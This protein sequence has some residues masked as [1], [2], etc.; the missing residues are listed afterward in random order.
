MLFLALFSRKNIIMT[1]RNI[2]ISVIILLLLASITGAWYIFNKPHRSLDQAESITV[3]ADSLLA[4]YLQDEKNANS[5]YLDKALVVSGEIAE[6]NKN[7]SGQTVIILQTQDPMA[8]VVCTLQKIPETGLK[9]GQQVQVMGFCSGY[10]SD[11]V[12]RD[13]QLIKEN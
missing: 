12:L 8:G 3:P 5:I 9:I 2:I 10:I 7:Q 11:V 4:S 1:K 6:I 13:C